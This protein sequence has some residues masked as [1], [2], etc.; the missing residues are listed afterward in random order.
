LR[1]EGAKGFVA[2]TQPLPNLPDGPHEKLSANYYYTRDGRREMQPALLVAN[3]E[4][5]SVLAAGEASG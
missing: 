3:N 1:Y 5:G 4:T 2:R